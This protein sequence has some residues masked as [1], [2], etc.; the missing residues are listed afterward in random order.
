VKT[1]KKTTKP[2]KPAKSKA[3]P[4]TVTTKSKK[5]SSSKP[6]SKAVSRVT[7]APLPVKNQKKSAKPSSPA[8]SKAKSAIVA[9]KSKKPSSSKPSPKAGSKTAEAMVPLDGLKDWC[10]PF[11]LAQKNVTVREWNETAEWARMNGYVGLEIKTEETVRHWND[12]PATKVSLNAIAQWCN[13]KSEKEG[14]KPCYYLDGKVFKSVNKFSQKSLL[15]WKKDENG[16]RLPTHEEWL[17]GLLGENLHAKLKLYPTDSKTPPEV[18][19]YYT[20]PV[21]ETE[22][23]GLEIY[24]MLGNVNEWVWDYSIYRQ[25]QRVFSRALGTNSRIVSS[26]KD[27]KEGIEHDVDKDGKYIGFRLARNK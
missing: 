13:A 26:L 23:N 5:P 19:S 4:P 16:Y 27:I 15:D 20:L 1:Q 8:K 22:P 9:A 7:T 18:V 25:E 17:F 11:H 3:K 14:L 24:G 10:D 21:D 12:S 6:S 2:S